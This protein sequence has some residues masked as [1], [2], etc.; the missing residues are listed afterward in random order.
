V[1]AILGFA[2]GSLT[3]STAGS[4]DKV[5]AASVE[6]AVERVATEE[7]IVAKTLVFVSKDT[8]DIE[9]IAVAIVVPVGYRALA[10]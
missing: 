5:V 2:R 1:A 6:K 3:G 4:V 7:G 10:Y 8:V 9:A